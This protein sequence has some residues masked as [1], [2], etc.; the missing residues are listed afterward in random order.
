MLKNIA[1]DQFMSP[2]SNLSSLNLVSDSNI[3]LDNL[4]SFNDNLNLDTID[5]F[6]NDL[7]EEAY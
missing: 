1:N 4:K 2:V 3:K 5:P 6:E 7:S